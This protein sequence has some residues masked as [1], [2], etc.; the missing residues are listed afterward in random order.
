[1][2]LHGS[3]NHYTTAPWHFIL[4]LDGFNHP[5]YQAFH[6]QNPVV[7]T[8]TKLCRERVLMKVFLLRGDIFFIKRE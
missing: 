5:S 1:M 3:D 8:P 6:F 7:Y 4:E 2:K